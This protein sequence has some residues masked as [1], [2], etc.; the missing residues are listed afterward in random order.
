MTE[1]H[2][3]VNAFLISKLFLCGLHIQGSVRC[4]AS[5]PRYFVA[6]LFLKRM[7][8]NSKQLKALNNVDSAVNLVSVMGV[9]VHRQRRR[10]ILGVFEEKECTRR[11]SAI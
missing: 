3:P 2:S 11:R 4:R 9:E 5:N 1:L 6:K 7:V 10:R 8:V